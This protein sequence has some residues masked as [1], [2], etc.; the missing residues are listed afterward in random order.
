M[1][2]LEAFKEIFSLY[3]YI[4]NSFLNICEANI[5]YAK[6]ISYCE[7]LYIIKPQGDTRQSVMRY[8][9]GFAA[10]DDIQPVRADYM[11]ILDKKIRG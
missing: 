11:P 6:R 2:K 10:L 5:S 7:A 4:S 3:S 8:K 9:G 1:T